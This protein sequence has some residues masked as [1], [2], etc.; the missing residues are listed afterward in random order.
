[1]NANVIAT[2]RW[3]DKHS[4]R[5]LI[6]IRLSACACVF[7]FRFPIVCVWLTLSAWCLSPVLL[8]KEIVSRTSRREWK[9]QNCRLKYSTRNMLAMA[10]APTT[11]HVMHGASGANMNMA[12][13]L[14]S[15]Q[16]LSYANQP[17]QYSNFKL[18]SIGNIWEH[19]IIIVPIE[20][21]RKTEADTFSTH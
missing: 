14:L 8:L 18:F 11:V 2:L 15:M 6:I 12:H 5:T 13:S 9:K 17:Q 10:Q 16:S 19:I 1:M 21:R 20:Y 3:R 4:H 7:S